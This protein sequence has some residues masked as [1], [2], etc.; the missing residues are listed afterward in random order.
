[1]SFLALAVARVQHPLHPRRISPGGGGDDGDDD[2][3]DDDDEF[4][5]GLSLPSPPV[6]CTALVASDPE[7]TT[8][9]TTTTT[10]TAT[11]NN[12]N[13]NNTNVWEVI[14]SQLKHNELVELRLGYR[15]SAWVPGSRAATHTLAKA[16][17]HNTSL[18]RVSIGWYWHKRPPHVLWQLLAV[19]AD[20]IRPHQLQSLQLVLTNH[21]I[22][23]QVLSNLLQSQTSLSSL[24]LQ[25]ITVDAASSSN[26]SINS[27][28]NSSSLD[29]NTTN[30]TT[31]TNSS[32]STGS[33]TTT[34]TTF[35]S[36]S[37]HGRRSHHSHKHGDSM[38]TTTKKRI[39]KDRSPQPLHPH[40]YPPQ[41]HHHPKQHPKQQKQLQGFKT[42]A[43]GYDSTVV[44][45]L[46]DSFVPNHRYQVLSELHLIDCDLDDDCLYQLADE[47]MPTTI[48]SIRGNR[49]VTGN[50]AAAL[51]RAEKAST[52]DLSLCDFQA[53]DFVEI[54][55]ALRDL[56]QTRRC[57]H[58][59]C[60][61]H[62]GPVVLEHLL[63]RGNYRMEMAG[64]QHL[65]LVAPW[66]VQSLD[67]SYCDL[68]E[69][70]TICIFQTLKTHHYG[71]R[72]GRCGG[73]DHVLSSE[74]EDHE[75]E[76]GDKDCHN[77]DN[78][79]EEGLDQ[80]QQQQHPPMLLRHLY[81]HGCRIRGTSATNALVALLRPSSSASSSQ[82]P[83]CW[84]RSLALDDDKNER[85]YLSATQIRE[86][87]K[88]MR[89]N[90]EMEAL[91]IDFFKGSRDEQHWWNEI[92]FWQ[93]LN[94]AGRRLLLRPSS[95]STTTMT[96]SLSSSSSSTTVPRMGPPP[97]N[98]KYDP[99]SVAKALREDM[100]GWIQLLDIAQSEPGLESIYWVVRNSADR[101]GK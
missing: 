1:M 93:V 33:T 39:K 6:P 68:T 89:Y 60:R 87:A 62:K 73:G 99:S 2:D 69:D 78:K 97:S 58:G 72:S 23:A 81:M 79:H 70:M 76:D 65:I 96:L 49:L 5:V 8:T 92:E 32:R 26:N 29:S 27:N 22:P 20:S 100:D 46:L 17:K 35:G 40:F 80:Q 9:T 30:E 18:R 34:T 101:F 51:I 42:M 50:G 28:S 91:T 15:D 13:N 44:P 11:P 55:R 66:V 10:S 61:R 71:N 21:M 37:H 41:P 63:V 3:D 38:M 59:C 98:H 45:I 14:V 94:R 12:N 56:A 53:L 83:C 85:K 43:T 52:L 47:I 19:L 77:D 75:E 7:P 57:G 90:Y 67:L 86:I 4:M 25:T 16:L 64:L 88:A 82:P 54:G 24:N 84:L 74:E 36:H 48:L 95:T 31:I